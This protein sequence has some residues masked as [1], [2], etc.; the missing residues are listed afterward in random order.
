MVFGSKME[1]PKQKRK[2]TMSTKYST[3]GCETPNN[4]VKW[5]VQKLRFWLP[6]YLE[7]YV[8]MES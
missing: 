4:S 3:G 6:A 8:S 2:L 1:R 7:C 5:T